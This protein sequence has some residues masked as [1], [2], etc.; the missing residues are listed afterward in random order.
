MPRQHWI[1]YPGAMYHIVARGNRRVKIFLEEMDFKIYLS[2]LEDVCSMMPFILHSNCLLTNHLHL[3]L[4]L[5]A[6]TS[7]IL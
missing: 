3:Q 6:I 2:I 1:W 4:E 5:Q 7:S